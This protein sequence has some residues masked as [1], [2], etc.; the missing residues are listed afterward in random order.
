MEE[1]VVENQRGLAIVAVSI[2]LLYFCRARD[3]E[4]IPLFRNWLVVPL[5]AMAIMILFL[6]GLMGVIQTWP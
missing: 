5:L 2:G 3:G 6:A 4:A 1:L